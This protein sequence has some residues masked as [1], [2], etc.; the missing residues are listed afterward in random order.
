MNDEETVALT[1]GGHTVG[2]AHGNGDAGALGPEPEAGAIENQGF[3]W[4]N[5][6]NNGN[7]LGIASIFTGIREGAQGVFK[8]I[9]GI[10]SP[11]T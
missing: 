11:K 4:M 5:P 8:G 9:S 1:A 2:K 7:G 10:F 3:G 6:K